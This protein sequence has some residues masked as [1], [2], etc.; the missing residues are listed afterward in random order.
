[1]TSLTT[2]KAGKCGLQCAQGK[3]KEMWWTICVMVSTWRTKLRGGKEHEKKKIFW[4][5]LPSFTQVSFLKAIKRLKC[6]FLWALLV[7]F[8]TL[9]PGKWKCCHSGMFD[10]ATPWTVACQALPSMEFSRQEHWGLPNSRDQTWI[11]CRWILDCLSHQLTIYFPFFVPSEKMK[12][13]DKLC[14]EFYMNEY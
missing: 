9:P 11:S 4:A 12:K 5:F 3:R 10:S 2:G 1:M 6:S 14:F 7:S 13:G 8:G